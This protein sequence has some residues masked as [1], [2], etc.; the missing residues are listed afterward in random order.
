MPLGM[1]KVSADR[2]R[3]EEAER[4]HIADNT[5]G[6]R[7]C[8]NPKCRAG[9]VHELKVASPKLGKKKGRAKKVESEATPD[10]I[11]CTCYECGAKACV[12]CDRPWHEGE[13]CAEY[14][15]RVKDRLD[16]EDQALEAIR[17]MTK[18][19]P[20][21]RKQIQKNGGCPMMYCELCLRVA[22]VCLL[23]VPGTQCFA[24]FCWDCTSVLDQGYCK[25]H[26]RPPAQAVG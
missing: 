6:W 19:C 10:L 2:T 21:C 23:T 25:C 16:E 8:M 11:I 14:Q 24:S 9:Q 17:K 7:W 22:D 18:P 3:F 13:T 1:G 5:P 15:V 26:P 4:K 12:S 20:G